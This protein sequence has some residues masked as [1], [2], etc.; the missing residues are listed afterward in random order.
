MA[1]GNPQGLTDW[2]YRAGSLAVQLRETLHN[3]DVFA[4]TLAATTDAVLLALGMAQAD[5]NTLRSAITDAADLSKVFNGTASVHL[6]GT[7]NY[8]Q[9]IKLLYGVA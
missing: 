2:N 5:I 3:I 7:Y 1:A 9:F 4:A 8:T 6:T